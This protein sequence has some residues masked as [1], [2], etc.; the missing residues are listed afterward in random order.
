MSIDRRGAVTI[1]VLVRLSNSIKDP[2]RFGYRE[3]TAEPRWIIAWMLRTVLAQSHDTA[4]A[5]DRNQSGRSTVICA[6][7]DWGATVLESRRMF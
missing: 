7:L 6:I 3:R 4:V 5:F 1:D 2:S